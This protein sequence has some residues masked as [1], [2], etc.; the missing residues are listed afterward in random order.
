MPYQNWLVP[1]IIGLVFL[2]A[3]GFIVRVML[4][5]DGPRKKEPVAV[6]LL[7]PPP[8]PPEVKEKPPEP[9]VQK[10]TPKE[11]VTP[12]E[13][14]QP[15]D[16]PDQSQDN[17]P[18]GE[19]LG[20]EGEGGAGDNAFGLRAKKGGRDV[21]LGGG[22]GGA[23]RFSLMAK[24][25]WYN[26]KISDEIRRQVRKRL[27]SDGGMPKGKYQ[28][29]VKVTLDAGGT[30]VEYTITT[31]SGNQRVDKAVQESLVGMRMSEP[32][33]EGMPRRMTIKVSSQG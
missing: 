21:T 32:P 14:Q 33:P 29:L 5:P 15:D 8:P 18:Q 4:S 24:Y 23:G 19:D 3:V 9:Q 1:G 26:Q 10:D 28:L 25:G 16:S 12:A 17:A 7:K 11:I 22:G 30:I 27:E 20:V 2:A 31:H 6:T 13:A